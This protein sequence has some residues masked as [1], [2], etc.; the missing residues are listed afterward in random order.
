VYEP[1]MPQEQT[2]WAGGGR[3]RR[4]GLGEPERLAAFPWRS[5]CSY[6]SLRRISGRCP[7]K[8]HT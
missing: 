8:H 2:P 4:R 3:G 5:L 6:Q 1:Q 7:I